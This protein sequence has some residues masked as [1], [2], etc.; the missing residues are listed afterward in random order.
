[1]LF[2]ESLTAVSHWH[3]KFYFVITLFYFYCNRSFRS[4][5]CCYRYSKLLLCFILCHSNRSVLRYGCSCCNI[6]N[7]FPVYR[8]C[9]I[10]ERCIKFLRTSFCYFPLIFSFIWRNDNTSPTFF[11]TFLPCPFLIGNPDF[12][13]T[14]NNI[15]S[16]CI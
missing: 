5:F 4:I 2:S 6:S 15:S 11:N 16:C 8:N 3:W 9:L 1:M 10:I 14:W 13:I 7:N 12:C